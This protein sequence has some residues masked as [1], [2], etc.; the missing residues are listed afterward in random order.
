RMIVRTAS[1]V[2]RYSKAGTFASRADGLCLDSRSTRI[3]KG[4]REGHDAKALKD[5]YRGLRRD[6]SSRHGVHAGRAGEREPNTGG[7]DIGEA[8]A[9]WSYRRGD[10]LRHRDDAADPF[11]GYGVGPDHQP[12]LRRLDPAGLQER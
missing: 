5:A 7:S 2:R 3:G 12:H 9:G 6:T 10:H 11:G 8:A 1:A 4:A